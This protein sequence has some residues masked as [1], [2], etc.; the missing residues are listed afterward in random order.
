MF[1]ALAFVRV[2]IVPF[3]RNKMA[4]LIF[5]KFLLTFVYDIGPFEIMDSNVGLL[6]H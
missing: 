6:T 4:L 3:R 2:E 5:D 1:K